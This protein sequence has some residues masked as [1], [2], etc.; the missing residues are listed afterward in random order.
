MTMFINTLRDCV[1]DDSTSINSTLVCELKVSNHEDIPVLDLQLTPNYRNNKNEES[2]AKF[3][4]LLED[5]LCFYYESFFKA[6]YEV[7]QPDAPNIYSQE[8]ISKKYHEVMDKLSNL[9]EFI[10]KLPL[11]LREPL[12]YAFNRLNKLIKMSLNIPLFDVVLYLEENY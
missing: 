3:K 7:I 4:G 8:V 2:L 10:K 12:I 1:F 11:D 5:L 9:H 6:E